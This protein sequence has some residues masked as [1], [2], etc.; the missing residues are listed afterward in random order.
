MDT[1][2]AWLRLNR[3]HISPKRQ[4]ELLVA[5]GSPQAVLSAQDYELDRVEGLSEADRRKLRREAKADIS[6]DLEMVER[7]GIDIVSI[8]DERYPKRLREIPEPPP[9]LFVAGTIE[10]RDELS[11]AMVGTRAATPYGKLVAERL[12]GDLGRKGFTVVSGLA[13]GIDQAAHRGALSAG[14]RTIGVLGCGLDVDY[15]RGSRELKQQMREAGAIITE[16][17]FGTEPREERFPTRNRIISG[18]S[19][20]VVVVE[21]PE[22]SGALLT[23][24]FAL[25]QNREVFAV[26]AN[27]DAPTSRGCLQLI[28]DGAKLVDSA[29]D[30]IDGLGIVPEAI[31]ESRKPPPTDL[32]PDEAAVIGALSH[33]PKHLDVLIQQTGLCAARATSALMLLE[34]KG[35][36]RRLPGSMFVRV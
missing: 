33:E 31:P 12:A 2:E 21:A 34:V 5:L 36:A 26:P 25:E 29:E 15:P 14:G 9:V 32:S 11:V 18:M 13:R 1:I 35:A 8:S 17:G 30:I 6:A 10:K 16:Y 23:A 7:S 3:T 20:G 28:K 19:L 4:L 27:I 22:R 24:D